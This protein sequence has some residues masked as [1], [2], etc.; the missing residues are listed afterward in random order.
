MLQDSSAAEGGSCAAKN[1]LRSELDPQDDLEW[2][3]EGEGQSC[4]L[5]KALGP[6]PSAVDPHSSHLSGL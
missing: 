2:P 6:S 4:L 3:V 5:Y 1:S